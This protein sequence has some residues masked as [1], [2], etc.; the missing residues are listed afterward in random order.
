MTDRGFI[1][2][3]LVWKMLDQSSGVSGMWPV[4]VCKHPNFVKCRNKK[5][6]GKTQAPQFSQVILVMRPVVCKAWIEGIRKLTSTKGDYYVPK[7]GARGKKLCYMHN[8]W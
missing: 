5:K 3:W 1:L 8:I 7:Q 2:L 6:W 4:V